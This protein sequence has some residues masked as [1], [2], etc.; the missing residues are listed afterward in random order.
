M[1]QQLVL[2]VLELHKQA[3]NLLWK[4]IH[5][6]TA[7]TRVSSPSSLC[8][9]LCVLKLGTLSNQYCN[10]PTESDKLP[11]VYWACKSGCYPLQAKLARTLLSIPTSSGSVERLFSVSGA[12]VT[13]RRSRLTAT[14]VESLLTA[15]ECE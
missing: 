14:T 2:D 13:A 10:S 9:M 7:A 3:K 11:E 8:H 4:T 6:L 12:I 15:M 5:S 1:L